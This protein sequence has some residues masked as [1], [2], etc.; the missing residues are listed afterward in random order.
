[1]EI[2]FLMTLIKL[3]VGKVKVK[4]KF[5]FHDL[6]FIFSIIVHNILQKKTKNISI[7]DEGQ[8]PST[9]TQAQVIE[10]KV[11]VKF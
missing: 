5:F 4:F 9:L 7:R 3:D 1:M 2:K 10:L 11:M 6:I 8:V